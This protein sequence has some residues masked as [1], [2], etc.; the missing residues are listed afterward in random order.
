M[1]TLVF[2]LE[3][4]VLLAVVKVLSLVFKARQGK[5]SL[6]SYYNTFNSKIYL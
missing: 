1:G 3:F 6:P 2:S 5:N 4:L